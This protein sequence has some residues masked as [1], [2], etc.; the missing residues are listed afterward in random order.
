VTALSLIGFAVFLVTLAVVVVPR[1]RGWW[2]F[3]G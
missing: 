1:K 3:F 2:D